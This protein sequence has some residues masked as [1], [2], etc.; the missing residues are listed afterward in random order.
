MQ[1]TPFERAERNKYIHVKRMKM[2]HKVAELVA[3]L[4]EAEDFLAIAEAQQQDLRPAD[5]GMYDPVIIETVKKEVRTITST[6]VI[7]ANVWEEITGVS[8]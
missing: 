3:R 7:M 5:Y 1:L 6:L 4:Q 2:T 8:A